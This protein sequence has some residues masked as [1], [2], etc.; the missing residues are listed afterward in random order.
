MTV[1]NKHIFYFIKIFSIFYITII[2]AIL[3]LFVSQFFDRYIF[4][5]HKIDMDEETINKTPL[6]KILIKTFLILGLYGVIGYIYRN[7]LVYIPFPLDGYR[8]FNYTRVK[9]VANGS[10][11]MIVLFTFSETIVK[12]YLQIKKKMRIHH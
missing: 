1:K 8:G 12:L 7:I 4:N 2:S 5:S 3:G 10:V 9:E 11:F 6:Y